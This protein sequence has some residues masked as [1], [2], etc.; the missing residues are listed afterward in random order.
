[1]NKLFRSATG[2]TIGEYIIYKRIIHA[3]GLIGH[4]MRISEAA[5]KSGFA[6]YSSFYRAY[7]KRMGHS[8]QCDCQYP[9]QKT[10]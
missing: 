10:T 3:R 1:M 8:P 5:E 6:D 9:E 2:T 7:V 4:G